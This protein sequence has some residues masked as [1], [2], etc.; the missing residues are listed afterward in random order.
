[1]TK[2]L[3]EIKKNFDELKLA[4][5]QS[6]KIEIF[7]TYDKVYIDTYYVNLDIIWYL[8]RFAKETGYLHTLKEKLLLLYISSQE[9]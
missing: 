9:Y 3:V 8:K 4:D 1:M 2:P 6:V 5:Y 7:I